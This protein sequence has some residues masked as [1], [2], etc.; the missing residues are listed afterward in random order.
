MTGLTPM[1]Y[2]VYILA[3]SARG[4]GPVLV[5][6]DVAGTRQRGEPL[7]IASQFGL[8]DQDAQFRPTRHETDLM[9]Q[10]L[11]LGFHR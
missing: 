10:F 2:L 1:V 11:E 5:K 4:L 7:S 8:L 3:D 9:S 6:K